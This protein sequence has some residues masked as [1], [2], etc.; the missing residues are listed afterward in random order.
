VSGG[1]GND[2][3]QPHALS[4]RRRRSFAVATTIVIGG[5]IGCAPAP[6]KPTQAKQEG[7]RQRRPS[8]RYLLSASAAV[9]EFQNLSI[10]TLVSV[11]L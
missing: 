7:R 4:A 11:T 9:T 1:T 10:S 2:V 5:D 6:V 8:R 3:G